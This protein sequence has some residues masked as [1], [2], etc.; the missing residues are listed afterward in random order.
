MVN[1]SINWI[2]WKKVVGFLVVSTWVFSSQAGQIN[3]TSGPYRTPLVELY[4]S[5]GCSSCPPADKWIS[6]LGETLNDGFHAVPLA[7][8]VDYWNR[9]GWPDPY[10]DP[11]FT[12]RQQELARNN[13]QRSIYTPEFLV[14]G[15]ETR[16]TTAVVRDIQSANQQLAE[17]MITFGVMPTNRARQIA[18]DLIIGGANVG[19]ELY[20]AVF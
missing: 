7:F 6:K 13:K 8:H 17:V 2:E 4:T 15:R 10:S 12:E 3:A 11:K 9:L 16:G 5:E 18:A 14:S 20:L 1:L 19:D